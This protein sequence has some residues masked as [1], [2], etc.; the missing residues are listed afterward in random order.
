MPAV[1]GYDLPVLVRLTNDTVL[2]KRYLDIGVQTLLIPYVQSVEEARRAVA[3]TRYP[4]DGA[5]GVSTVA[6]A[7]RRS[8]IPHYARDAAR[9]I[10]VLVQIETQEALDCLEEIAA[11]PG[12]DGIF[13]GPSDL[14]ASLGHVGNAGHADVK[15]AIEKAV[16]RSA[17][18]GK[19]R[20]IRP[21]C[22]CAAYHE[23]GLSYAA[24]GVDSVALARASEAL[25]A[26]SGAA[27]KLG[28]CATP[29]PGR[30][31]EAA[32]L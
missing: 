7:G 21:I 15:A 20:G 13:I 11:V 18:L 5:R 28:W 8:C 4:P 2:I 1:A 22:P 23:I 10:C 25:L 26:D 31:G 19:P 32:G 12:I 30:S 16:R 6:R 17:A 24:I 27:V 14:A 9:E 29:G 3:A